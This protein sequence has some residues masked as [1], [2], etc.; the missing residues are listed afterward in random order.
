ML[1]TR[2]LEA[3]GTVGV[4]LLPFFLVDLLGRF[5]GVPN[6]GKPLYRQKTVY[7]KTH[8]TAINRPVDHTGEK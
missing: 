5:A 2:N 4:N 6:I 1:L 7:I 8:R 3:I